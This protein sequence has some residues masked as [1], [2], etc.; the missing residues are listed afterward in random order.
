[1][2]IIPD[3]ENLQIRRYPTP[4]EAGGRAG[5]EDG[6]QPQQGSE[7]FAY[8][9]NK[10]SPNPASVLCNSSFL[11]YLFIYGLFDSNGRSKHR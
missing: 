11:V 2:R 7:R 6:Y 1:M 4:G 8:S 10:G 5:G 9:L 3:P